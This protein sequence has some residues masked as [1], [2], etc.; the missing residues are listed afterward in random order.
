MGV[1]GRGE[2]LWFLDWLRVLAVFGVFVFH[3]LRPFDDGD[4]HVKNAQTS[5]GIS[6]AIAFLGL[7]GLA[8][9]FMISGAASWLALRWRSGLAFLRERAL[10]LLVPFVV[11]YVL[12][13][14]LQYF[15]EQHHKGRSSQSFFGDVRTFFGDLAGD[16]PLWLRDTYHLWFLIYLIQFAVLGLPLFLLF[17]GR[18]DWLARICQRRGSILLLAVPLIPIH[19][20]LLAAPGPDHGWGE[21]VFFFDFFVVGFVVMSDERLTAAVR[22]DAVP[23]LI[24]GITA[25]V[26]GVLTG[27]IDFLDGWWPD[28]GY[29]WAY[30]W[31]SPLITIAVWGWLVAVLG[32]G[33]RAPAFQRPLP[34]PLA[35][36]AM[37]YFIVHQPIILA[38]AYYVVRWD[39]GIGAKYAVLLPTAFALSAVLAWLLSVLPGIS[40]LFGV[41]RVGSGGTPFVNRSKADE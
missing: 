5:E 7:W 6:M 39:T 1:Q 41:K 32:F 14:P 13:S 4:W 11:A 30:L 35:R 2:R 22:R 31:Y 23:G 29:S 26:V 37:P 25:F 18:V 38:I 33:M 40:T 36:A 12:L 34:T 9:F 19:L 24:V 15:I 17:R 3:T 27:I 8:F 28:P 10:R 16:A 21:F 20:L